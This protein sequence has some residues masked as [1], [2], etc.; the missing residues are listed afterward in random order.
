MRPPPGAGNLKPRVGAQYQAVIPEMRPV[1]RKEDSRFRGTPVV[2]KESKDPAPGS[3]RSADSL[4]E[5]QLKSHHVESYAKKKA[6]RT[7]EPD[8]PV[9]TDDS[10]ATESSAES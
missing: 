1:S 3:K 9:T 7:S 8:D 5:E 10:P 6:P 2:M 4:D